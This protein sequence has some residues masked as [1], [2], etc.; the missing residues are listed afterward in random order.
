MRSGRVQRKRL[1]NST[2]EKRDRIRA[3]DMQLLRVFLEIRE[4]SVVRG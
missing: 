2:Q 3:E 4:G 1:T